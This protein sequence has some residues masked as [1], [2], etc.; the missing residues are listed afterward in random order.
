MKYHGNKHSKCTEI[1]YKQ[2][3][4]PRFDVVIAAAVANTRENGTVAKKK[5]KIRSVNEEMTKRIQTCSR[6]FKIIK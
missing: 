5:K 2:S 4:Q 6:L 3:L 1:L